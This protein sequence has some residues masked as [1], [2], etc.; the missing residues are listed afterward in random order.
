[1]AF[2]KSTTPDNIVQS[3]E[4]CLNVQYRFINESAPLG[5]PAEGKWFPLHSKD[6]DPDD[7]MIE[8]K[9]NIDTNDIYAKKKQAKN[10]FKETKAQDRDDE[11]I[12]LQPCLIPFRMWQENEQ[13][14][15]SNQDM[16]VTL[17]KF[18]EEIKKIETEVKDEIMNTNSKKVDSNRNS[19]LN[20]F[21]IREKACS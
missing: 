9:R 17:K 14:I 21:I 11:T 12:S 6:N 3:E 4:Y 2:Q 15:V 5:Q 18:D 19:K 20:L 7:D 10:P 8:I 16:P 1:M 13:G